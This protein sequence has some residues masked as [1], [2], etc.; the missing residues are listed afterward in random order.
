MSNDV[1]RYLESIDHQITSGAKY[2]WSCYPNARFIDSETDFVHASAVADARTGTIYEARFNLANYLGSEYRW[3]NPDWRDAH[4]QEAISRNIDL[5]RSED[6]Q[7]LVELDNLDDLLDK[8]FL[9]SR[10]LEFDERVDV[11][12]E[13]TDAQQLELFRLAHAQDVSFNEFIGQV[14]RLYMEGTQAGDGTA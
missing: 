3:M 1:A 4:D 14:L 8:L 5:E 11:V 9:A 6:S 12:I 7:P 13:L 10:G 2:E